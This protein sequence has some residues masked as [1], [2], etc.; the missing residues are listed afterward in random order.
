[1]MGA[2]LTTFMKTLSVFERT[3]RTERDSRYLQELPEHILRDIG[4]SRAEI[5]SLMSAGSKKAAHCRH[6]WG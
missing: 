3:F 6:N 2:V 5:A 4:M 1:M